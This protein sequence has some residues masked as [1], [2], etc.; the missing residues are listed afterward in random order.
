MKEIVL[1]VWTIVVCIVMTVGLIVGNNEYEAAYTEWDYRNSLSDLYQDTDASFGTPMFYVTCMHNC[2]I[3]NRRSV[4]Y[5]AY[6]RHLDNGEIWRSVAD[7]CAALLVV[8][9][10]ISLIDLIVIVKKME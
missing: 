8:T 5:A 4:S 1:L 3:I 10:V 7:V 9:A 2:K 6:M